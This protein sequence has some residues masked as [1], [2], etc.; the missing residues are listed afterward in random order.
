MSFLL[1]KPIYNTRKL[2]RGTE[3]LSSHDV[4]VIY[5]LKLS[6]TISPQHRAP[7]PN[8]R[9]THTIYGEKGSRGHE[10]RMKR[11][12]NKIDFFW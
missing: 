8:T 11:G 12:C 10:I 6:Y 4:P 3:F 9:Q 5:I 7:G 2:H 1:V